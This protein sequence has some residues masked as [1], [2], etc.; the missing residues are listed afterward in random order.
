M[1]E[2]VIVRRSELASPVDEAGLKTQFD[3]VNAELSKVDGYLGAGIWLEVL[4][5]DHFL[6]LQMYDSEEAADR[7]YKIYAE[8]NLV[9]SFWKIAKHTV[10]VIRT[11][12]VHAK[13]LPGARILQC[14]FISFSQ[15]VAVPGQDRGLEK[16]LQ[17]VLDECLLIPG[18]LGYRIG[19]HQALDE[20]VI[21]IVGWSSHEAF[22]RSVPKR[23]IPS[24]KCYRKAVP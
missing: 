20:E 15:R 17:I 7:G 18:C 9:G 24:V 3:Q 21:G 14:P 2:T 22:V 16:D 12:T 8:S 23:I 19:M 6:G 1:Q 13:L 5:E 10:D 11:R 4:K